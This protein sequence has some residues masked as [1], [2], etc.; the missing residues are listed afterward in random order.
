MRSSATRMIQRGLA[1][2]SMSGFW[3]NLA[4]KEAL[5]ETCNK[6]LVDPKRGC[7]RYEEDSTRNDHYAGCDKQ[8]R[9]GHAWP[10]F[11]DCAA[12]YAAFWTW[13]PLLSRKS[14]RAFFICTSSAAGLGVFGSGATSRLSPGC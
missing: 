6:G 11:D 10:S 14:S 1:K 13:T 12:L 3:R 9:P 8:K 2:Q 4:K 5:Q 7:T